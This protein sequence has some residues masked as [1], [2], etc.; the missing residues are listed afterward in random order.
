MHVPWDVNVPRHLCG[1]LHGTKFYG[2]QFRLSIKD[3]IGAMPELGKHIS[4][5]RYVQDEWGRTWVGWLAG[6]G[7]DKWHLAKSRPVGRNWDD[8]EAFDRLAAPGRWQDSIVA[9][10]GKHMYPFLRVAAF[11]MVT[12]AG[13]SKAFIFM[14]AGNFR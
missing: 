3:F 9:T 4:S 13:K 2:I 8:T 1:Y 5:P 14:S 12:C 10:S 11:P 7:L 6:F